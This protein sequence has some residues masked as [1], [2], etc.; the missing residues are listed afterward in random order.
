MR[1]VRGEVMSKRNESKSIDVNPLKE[2]TVIGN[3]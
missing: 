3:F 2:T 1:C